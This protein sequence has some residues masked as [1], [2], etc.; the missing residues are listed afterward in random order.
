MTLNSGKRSDEQICKNTS[1]NHVVVHYLPSLP[2]RNK[3]PFAVS[4]KVGKL[5]DELLNLREIQFL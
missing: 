3:Y 5:G 4:Y 1:Q 2:F